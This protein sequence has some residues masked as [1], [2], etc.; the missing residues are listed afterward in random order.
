M[1]IHHEINTAQELWDRVTGPVQCEGE[2]RSRG[3]GCRDWYETD[4]FEHAM[5]LASEGWAEGAKQ[6]EHATARLSLLAGSQLFLPETSYDVV[7]DMLDM[8]A[9]MEGQPEHW[10]SET[11]S[12]VVDRSSR[13]RLIQIV[14][15]IGA[16]GSVERADMIR[17]AAAIAAV[18]NAIESTGRC[19]EII[20]HRRCRANSSSYWSVTFPIKRSEEPLHTGR[21]AFMCGHPSMHRRCMFSLKETEPKKI[22]DEFNYYSGYG[23]SQKIANNSPLRETA[24]LI[25]DYDWTEFYTDQSAAAKVQQVLKDLGLVETD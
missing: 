19:A 17:R 5:Q 7:G 13:G 23:S 22:R 6:C 25:F 12:E 16:Q 4:S 18:C 3:G 1:I 21:L 2:R 9:V 24:D 20:G 10:L 15:N 14:V 8:G 11:D